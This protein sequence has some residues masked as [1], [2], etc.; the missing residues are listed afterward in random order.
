MSFIRTLPFLGTRPSA[1]HVSH[2]DAQQRSASL[3]LA[4]L[5]SSGW[6]RSL[7]HARRAVVMESLLCI[8]WHVLFPP[9]AT[10]SFN[11]LN[12]FGLLVCREASYCY[13]KGPL[14]K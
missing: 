2:S 4:S 3:A 14:H 1:C 8:S 10:V 13:R 7:G 5:R 12:T 9:H 6:L 11:G